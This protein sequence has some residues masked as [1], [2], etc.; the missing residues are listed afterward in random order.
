MAE[1]HI[2]NDDLVEIL[3]LINRTYGYDFSD[4]SR[5]SIKRRIHRSMDMSN[6]E[7]AYELKFRLANDAEYFRWFLE[8]LTVNV[9]E[10]F[11]D[12]EFYTELREKVFPA[13]ATYPIIKIW[14]AGCATGEEVYSMAIML[15]EAGLLERA[16]IYATDLNPLNIE[17]AKK[18]ITSLQHVKSY[19]HN[20]IRSGGKTDFSDYYSAQYG[21]AIISSEL[22][23]NILFSQH[24]LV[25]DQVFN[26]FQLI[27]CR[28]VLIYFNKDLQN[29][30]ISLFYDSLSPMGYLAIGTKESLLF[31]EVRDR[32]E[33]IS[34]ENKIFRRKKSSTSIK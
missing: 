30:V 20:Y 11:R 19:T 12:P 28:N 27:C 5:A 7:T 24:N 18:G 32:F 13:L 2:T 4:Y 31:T 16:K 17:K 22:R 15:K 23:K 33:V 14:H 8:V 6:L 21:A 34:A 29:R 26:E 3:H 1:R 9:T 10:M 25:T